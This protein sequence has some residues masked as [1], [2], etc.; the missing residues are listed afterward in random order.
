MSSAIA[1]SSK[2]SGG[3]VD[4]GD[5]YN[6]Q[7]CHQPLLLDPSMHDITPSQY[8]LIASNLPAPAP[9][10]TL[11]ASSKLASLPPSSQPGAKVWAE[12]N[13]L[14][15][16]TG[17]GSA[18]GRGVA[19][20]YILL[21]E[22]ALMPPPPSARSTSRASST[23]GSQLPI[24]VPPH[25]EQ[26]VSQLHSV[27]SSNTPIS[28]PLCT[29][30]TALLT[31]EFQKMAE[32]LT[33]E[34]DA[35]ISFEQSIQRN[36]DRQRSSSRPES[37]SRAN[38]RRSHPN[39]EA[40][41]A[42]GDNRPG[43]GDSDIEGTEDEWDELMRRK[44]ELEAEEEQLKAVLRNKEEELDK[45]KEEE[46]RVKEDEEQVDREETD[47]LL[48]H[49]ALSSHLAHL[50]ATLSTAQTHL[51]LSQSLLSHLES[52]N[53]YNDAFQIGH[54]PLD[55][56]SHSGITV[57]TINGLRLGGRPTVEW[58]EINAA[59]GLVALCL[60]RVA[61]KVG[62]KFQTYKIVP[63]GSYS[64]VEEL[65]PSKNVYELYASSDITPAR[66]LQNRRFNHAMVGLLDC[67]RQLVEFGKRYGKWAQANIEIHK[68]KIGGHSI[69]L[70]GI[71]SMPLGLPSMSIM[72]LGSSSSSSSNS[73]PNHNEGG[74]GRDRGDTHKS[75]SGGGSGADSTAEENWTRAC[76]AVLV[77]LKSVLIAASS[78]A[79]R[80]VDAGK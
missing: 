18:G 15:P 17:S 74:G 57:G 64:R 2:Q 38:S 11:P 26:L 45:V 71:S 16:A 47:Y 69:R 37:S 34:R 66:L 62:C 30:C 54:V 43:L 76:R 73:N 29:E 59:W 1:G 20:S 4:S 27:L 48:A 24:S 44:Q 7:R 41:H 75:S 23:S 19:E 55:P 79:D 56:N 12:A 9:A 36:R 67:L 70:P 51:L 25:S 53:V 32:E 52:T 28:H 77:V 63:L 35:Y 5:S 78:E 31:G 14:V 50:T 8:S 33:K 80:G 22:S 21:S 10:S 40:E 72:G 65:P 46:Q 49:S 6:C 58:E 60:D 3:G 61:D 68:D 39:K 42:D 13:H